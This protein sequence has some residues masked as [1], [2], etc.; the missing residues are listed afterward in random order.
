MIFREMDDDENEDN[1]YQNEQNRFAQLGIDEE[2]EED[3]HAEEADQVFD[4]FDAGGM[5]ENR[6]AVAK[7]IQQ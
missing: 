3:L 7:T 4:N 1:Q 6:G 5:S 2:D